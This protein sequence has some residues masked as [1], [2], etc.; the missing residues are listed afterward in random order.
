VAEG[1]A[2]RYAAT[3]LSSSTLTLVRTPKVR[4]EPDSESRIWEIRPFGSMRGGRESVIGLVPF[5]PTSPAYSTQSNQLQPVAANC[6]GLHFGIRSISPSSARTLEKI[7]WAIMAQ[8]FWPP[9][10]FPA[11]RISNAICNERETQAQ[12]K[13]SSQNCPS[14]FFTSPKSCSKL[15]Q[16]AA[17]CG[18]CTPSSL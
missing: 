1:S 9:P 18:G 16:I 6:S 13:R 8:R 4:A 10:K 7:N 3:R 11:R 15:Q 17:S 2:R 5:N 14:Y 12:G